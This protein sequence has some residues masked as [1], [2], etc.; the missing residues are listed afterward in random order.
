MAQKPPERARCSVHKVLS[1]SERALQAE[2]RP[3]DEVIATYER[4]SNAAPHRAEALHDASRFC[5]E[6]SRFAEGY[7][8][9]LC[10]L[11]VP[12]PGGGL[13]FQQSIYDYGLLDEFAV[14]AYWTDRYAEVCGCCDRLLSE[15]KMPPE[16]HD[17]AL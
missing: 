10:G 4:A 3:F 6:N 16:M 1:H 8:Y 15:G 14:N 2:E 7:K 13:S 17:I 9:A 5:R 12:S 11:S